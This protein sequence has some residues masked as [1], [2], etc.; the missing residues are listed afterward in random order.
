[1][2]FEPTDQLAL[3][4]HYSMAH[5]ITEAQNIELNWGYDNIPWSVDTQKKFIHPIKNLKR[6]FNGINVGMH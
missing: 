3:V 5:D 2:W 6:G 1:V 4:G